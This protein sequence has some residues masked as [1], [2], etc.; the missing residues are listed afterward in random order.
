MLPQL[1]A[2]VK[3]TLCSVYSG[4]KIIVEIF[5]ILQISERIS[6]KYRIIN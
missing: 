5:L 4:C 2:N 1:Y 6:V 3:F